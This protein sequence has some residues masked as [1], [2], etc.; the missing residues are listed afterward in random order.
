MLF[1]LM[2][3]SPPFLLYCMHAEALRSLSCRVL[4]NS[5]AAGKGGQQDLYQRGVESKKRAGRK[6][7]VK[8]LAI[9]LDAIL[10]GSSA[11]QC[12]CNKWLSVLHIIH[13][14]TSSLHIPPSI[15]LWY[16]VVDDMPSASSNY[17]T[18]EVVR[19]FGSITTHTLI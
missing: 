2:L 12:N 16:L 18:T 4:T 7:E 9:S 3:A 11:E 14:A 10:L 8:M 5:N 13:S 15:M 1:Y 19:L 6:Q 17:H